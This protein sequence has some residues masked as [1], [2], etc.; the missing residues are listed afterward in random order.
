MAM[1]TGVKITALLAA[2]GEGEIMAARFPGDPKVGAGA[3]PFRSVGCDPAAAS[4]GLGEEVGQLMAQ[5]AIDFRLA[6][7]GE[8]AIEQNARVAELRPP[9]GG[10]ES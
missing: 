2:N 8:A 9:G 10:T 5:G 4:A 7:R 3:T 6:V 1:R